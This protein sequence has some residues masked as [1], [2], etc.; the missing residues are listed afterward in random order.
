L[1]PK[2]NL[3]KIRFGDGP[4][5]IVGKVTDQQFVDEVDGPENVMDQQQDPTVVIV[6]ADHERIEAQDAVEDA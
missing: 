3:F 2:I 5:Q 4:P 1:E 6:P